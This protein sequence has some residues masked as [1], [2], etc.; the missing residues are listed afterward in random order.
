[1]KKKTIK[2]YT[3]SIVV[4]PITFCNENILLSPNLEIIPPNNILWNECVALKWLLNLMQLLSHQFPWSSQQ[5]G[6]GCCSP[7]W[8]HITITSICSRNK[9]YNAVIIIDNEFEMLFNLCSLTTDENCETINMFEKATHVQMMC[10]CVQNEK[11]F[12][13]W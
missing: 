12:N 5:F 9:R 8:Q 13:H 11:M 2:K 1:M 7:H 6:Y 4:W 3:N 10:V